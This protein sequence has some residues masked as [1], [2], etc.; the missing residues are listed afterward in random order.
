MSRPSASTAPSRPSDS[1]AASRPSASAALRT[2]LAL[3]TPLLR[4]ATTAL[5]QPDSLRPRYLNYLAAM[6][7]LI[8]A[9]VPLLELAAEWCDRQPPG[10]PLAAPL[11]RYFRLH[12][13]Q[14]RGHD[15]WLL[16]DLAAAGAEAPSALPPVVVAELSGA[17]YYWIRHHHPVVLLG[18]IAALE[19][20]AP[21]PWLA[22]RLAEHTGLPPAAFRT[23]RDHAALDT[24]HLADLENLLDELP[25]TAAQQTAVAVSALHTVDGI[26]RLFRQLADTS[27]H[28]GAPG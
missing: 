8:Q 25:L 22:D 10:D 2:K 14:E 21:A 19:G 26:T 18:Y 9:S 13:E 12:A 1:A 23:L 15:D 4:A 5:W 11:A 16:A 3:T 28:P 17:Q 7:G 20:N 6:H 27:E 24:G